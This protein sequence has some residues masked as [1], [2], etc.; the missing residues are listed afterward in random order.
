MARVGERTN[1]CQVTAGISKK[2]QLGRSGVKYENAIEMELQK[3]DVL[4]W[5]GRNILCPLHVG[6]FLSR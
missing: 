6:K 5:G 2:Q 4:V 1:A 3:C